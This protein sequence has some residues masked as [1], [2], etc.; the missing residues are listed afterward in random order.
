MD[1]KNENKL[2]NQI[3][4]ENKKIAKKKFLQ[5]ARNFVGTITSRVKSSYND[6]VTYLD[7]KRKERI[8]E[9]QFQDECKK[10]YQ[11]YVNSYDSNRIGSGQVELDAYSHSNKTTYF[12]DHGSLIRYYR[13]KGG[14]ATSVVYEG[15]VQD[16]N[17]N[18]KWVY[19]IGQ[20]DTHSYGNYDATEIIRK[21]NGKFVKTDY[22]KT[23]YQ[24]PEMFIKLRERFDEV[25]K[26]Y[27]D[28][29][30]N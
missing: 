28:L 7:E 23:L 24:K 21:P 5:P 10:R 20:Y 14:L 25:A 22:S 1:N 15:M 18:N 2:E 6:F 3:K 16:P 27:G 17:R 12:T 8:A 9:K 4:S 26:E 19:A 13:S 11:E 30:L 29:T